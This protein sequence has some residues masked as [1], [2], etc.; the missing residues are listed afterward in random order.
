MLTFKLF[1]AML[2]LSSMHSKLALGNGYSRYQ[3]NRGSSLPVTQTSTLLLLPRKN[4]GQVAETAAFSYAFLG[5]QLPSSNFFFH[6]SLQKS[7]FCTPSFSCS[8]VTQFGPSKTHDFIPVR[9]PS[10]LTPDGK[11][12][13]ICSSKLE[14]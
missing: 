5:S 7:K 14:R 12:S 2:I 13:S 6:S 9:S 1:P 8:C 11:V 3:V 10:H 4:W